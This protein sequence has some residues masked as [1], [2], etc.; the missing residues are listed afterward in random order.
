[1]FLAQDSWELFGILGI[2]ALQNLKYPEQ[3]IK[4]VCLCIWYFKT[5]FLHLVGHS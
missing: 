5:K 1:M 4:S 3:I 2:L